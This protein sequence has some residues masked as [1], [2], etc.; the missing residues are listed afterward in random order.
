M[1]TEISTG[2]LSRRLAALSP[3]RRALAAAADASYRG[4][5]E[6]AGGD[7][8]SAQGRQRFPPFGSPGAH[9]VQP[10]VEP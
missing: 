8:P 7:S 4:G 5:D 10:P 3:D 9:V 2:D 6:F 1:P